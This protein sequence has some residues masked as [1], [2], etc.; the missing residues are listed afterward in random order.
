MDP[1]I[2][3]TEEV[4]PNN[5]IVDNLAGLNAQSMDQ[6]IK[7][8]HMNIRSIR[9][10]GDE[11]FLMLEQTTEKFDILVLTETF[12]VDDLYMFRKPGYNL[13]YSNGGINKNDGVIVYINDELDA[14]HEIVN[15][16][17]LKAIEIKFIRNKES[18]L[19]TAIYRPPCTSVID[20]NGAM[21]RYLKTM[22][23]RYTYH[24]IV[25]DMNI[26][27]LSHTEFTDEYKN[28]L[29]MYNYI[30]YI[31]SYTRP[32]SETCLDHFYVKI[33][34]KILENVISSFVIREG[35]TDHFPI[36]LFIKTKSLDQKH[37]RKY[38]TRVI[39]YHSLR[40]DLK[41]ENWDVIYTAHDSNRD[42]DN[43]LKKLIYYIDKN[44]SVYNKHKSPRKKWITPKILKEV[45]AK[46]K[47]Y[48]EILKK[49]TDVVLKSRYNTLKINLRKAINLSKKEHLA[50]YIQNNRSSAKAL[51]SFVDDICGG[52]EKKK[53]DIKKIILENGEIIENKNRISN[54][55]NERYSLLGEKY[56]NKIIPPKNFIDRDNFVDKT[57]FLHPTDR[58]EVEKIINGLKNGKSAGNDGI[59]AET[60]KEICKEISDP[61]SQ[62]INNCMSS[63][64]FPN[65]LKTGVI[66]PLYKSGSTFKM[67]NYRPVTI[68]SNIAKIFEKIIANRVVSFLEKN[69]IISD[70][71]FG[72]RPKRS[73]EDAIKKLTNH[74]YGSLDR[75]LPCLSL[76]IDLC[77]AFDTVCHETLLHKLYRYG[78]RGICYDLL[79]DY[80]Y[81]RE[82]YVDLNGVKSEKRNI[83]YG[84]PQ[85]TVLGPILFNIYLN[86]LLSLE[87][88]G[89][90]ICYA[91]DAAIFYS[92]SSWFELKNKAEQDLH[93][94]QQWFRYNKLTLN[95]AK[96]KYL[97]FSSY[98]SGIPNMGPLREA[99]GVEIEEA[100]HIKY[101]GIIIDRHL[102]WDLQVDNVVR[103]IRFMLGRFRRMAEIL[104]FKQMKTLYH[105]LIESH[106]SYGILGWGAAYDCHLN[107]LKIIQKSFLKI[108][109]RKSRT[110]SSEWTYKEA[111]VMDLAQLYAFKTLMDNHKNKNDIT[112]STHTYPTRIKGTRPTTIRAE[113]T[114]G[115]R[116][117]QYLAPR[118][119]SILPEDI[120]NIQNCYQFRYKLKIWIKNT[121][122]TLLYNIINSK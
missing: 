28:M 35:I 115:Q 58:L 95:V 40:T 14:T 118:I 85:G 82:Q 78:L 103:K 29:S 42:V 110:Y 83:T 47:L 60:L 91:D 5:I 89:E 114:I 62:L 31:N 39:N 100:D 99:N 45:S 107:R 7:I 66:K 116:C 79:K 121:E 88:Q 63:G 92:S 38:T 6:A 77:K 30:S 70:C 65:I 67:E 1:L 26:D 2:R 113:K 71:Q 84:V 108:I 86:S 13:A 104:D 57:I 111:E 96:T 3:D 75:K 69:N 41:N 25:G 21:E 55:F 9:K 122:R 97:T 18:F 51:W 12:T 90:I 49:P 32:I 50:S 117:N 101:L 109:L 94:I 34:K 16:D 10:N 46:N 19:L 24:I 112:H 37:H 15:I 23:N 53:K 64:C 72:F 22:K 20:F 4:L 8:L 54:L 59:K 105:A 106:L 81:N 11:F 27:T 17:Q 98:S 43:F 87:L 120:R 56:A 76:F 61:L 102:K 33:G 68:I 44:T 80:L 119:F 48:L 73:T 74:I 93:Q 52:P 36:A